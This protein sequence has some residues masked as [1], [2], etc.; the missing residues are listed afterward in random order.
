MKRFVITCSAL[1]ILVPIAC[2]CDNN[3][4]DSSEPMVATSDKPATFVLAKPGGQLDTRQSAVQVKIQANH[5][6][7]QEPFIVN[8]Y[9]ETGNTEE[10][11][12]SFSFFPPIREGEI[13][14]VFIA[15]P[16]TLSQKDTTLRLNSSP[17]I[18]TTLYPLRKSRFWKPDYFTPRASNH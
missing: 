6:G 13:K 15:V 7:D 16:A 11:V 5:I 12:S 1:C 17:W 10:P 4:T 8:V 3:L 14:D 18:R 2:Q 9:D